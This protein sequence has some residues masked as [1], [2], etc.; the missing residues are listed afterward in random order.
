MN[1]SA[2]QRVERR[3]DQSGWGTPGRRADQR[4][5]RLFPKTLSEW[6]GPYQQAI[7][8]SAGAATITMFSGQLAG[9]IPKFELLLQRG[10]A[11]GLS[12][13][14]NEGLKR[15]CDSQLVSIREQLDRGPES[16]GGGDQVL[17]CQVAAAREC[18]QPR[19]RGQQPDRARIRSLH[20]RARR[21]VRRGRVTSIDRFAVSTGRPRRAA[22]DLATK[23]AKAPAPRTA[24]FALGSQPLTT[25]CM[26]TRQ[27][28][29]RRRLFAD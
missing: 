25:L 17:R 10:D 29:S 20:G 22:C 11:E 24:R 2:I 21:P 13:A 23:R 16:R 14:T 5:G 15:S 18:T 12:T 27:A 6:G 28:G 26:Q 9:L 4:D 7:P 3:I 19:S 8:P 1:C